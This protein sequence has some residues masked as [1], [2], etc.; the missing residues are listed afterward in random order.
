MQT[1][2]CWSVIINVIRALSLFSVWSAPLMEKPWSQSPALRSSMARSI[3]PMG[4]SSVGQRYLTL[5]H[6]SSSSF[7]LMN[8]IVMTFKSVGLS[9]FCWTQNKIF[10]KKKHFVRTMNFSGIQCNF[11]ANIKLTKGHLFC[12]KWY[13]TIFTLYIKHCVVS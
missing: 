6:C 9:F 3:Q 10:W 8:S 2:S 1:S 11:W 7:N 4:K 12:L 13:N 5:I